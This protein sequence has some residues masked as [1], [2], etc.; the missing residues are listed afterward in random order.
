[1][2]SSTSAVLS[3]WE[4]FLDRF[5]VAY[6]DTSTVSTHTSMGTVYKKK[7]TF[8]V[9]PEHMEEFMCEYVRV[10]FEHGHAQ[11]LTERPVEHSSGGILKFDL[12]FKYDADHLERLFTEQVAKQ[13][14]E[15]VNVYIREHIVI[16][17]DALL[18]AYVFQRPGPYRKDLIVKDGIHIMYPNLWVNYA[19]HHYLRQKLI[20]AVTE[21]KT[22][23]CIPHTNT[24]DDVIDESIIERNGWLMYGSTKENL[25]PYVLTVAYDHDMHVMSDMRSPGEL[26]RF[27]SIRKKLSEP[28]YKKWEEWHNFQDNKRKKKRRDAE[29]GVQSPT[30]QDISELEFDDSVVHDRAHIEKLV[31][32]LSH[33]R[34]MNYTT[35]IEVGFC[36]HNLSA[37]LFDLWIQFSKQNFDK[38]YERLKHDRE[39]EYDEARDRELMED[40]ADWDE[41]L[42][43]KKSCKQVQ[44]D[45]FRRYIKDE[46]AWYVD[47]FEKWRRFTR[48][49]SCLGIGSLIYWAKKDNEALFRGIR[50][51]KIRGLIE[52]SVRN[53]SHKKIADVLYAKHKHQFVCSD[54]KTNVWYGWARHCWEYM[55]GTSIIQ[56]KIKDDT[57]SLIN[58]YIKIKDMVYKDVILNN[59]ELQDM[60][61]RYETMERELQSMNMANDSIERAKTI[62]DEIKKCKTDRERKR[63]ELFKEHVR[64]YEDVITRF[65]E[66][67]GQMENIVKNAKSCFYDKDFNNKLNANFSLFLFNNGVFDLE[68]MT[69][70][71]GRPDDYLSIE[72]DK[73]Q[74]DYIEYS[75]DM[76][77]PVFR[78]I[79]AYFRQ[80]IAHDEKREFFLTLLASCL[81]GGNNN[82]I[83]PIL[84]GSGSNAKTLT[85]SFIEDCFVKYG[86][87]LNSAFLTQKRNKSSSASP[88][89]HTV[90]DCR[91]VTSEEPDQDDELNTAIIKEITGNSKVSS[92]TLF[93]SKMTT[94]VPQFT[95]FLI[96]NDLPHIKSFDGGTWRR[97]V[98]ISFD[99]KFV[100]NPESQEWAGL[101]NVYKIN[102]TLRMEM[103]SW[104]EPFMYLL[105]H[106]YYRRFLSMGKNLKIPECVQAFTNKFKTENDHVAR[107]IDEHV[108]RV[109]GTERLRMSD[110]YKHLQEWWL[111]NIG[112]S[113]RVP[114]QTVAKKSFEKKFGAHERNGWRGLRYVHADANES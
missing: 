2:A 102:R 27:F 92:R 71:E 56:R 15:I 61:A 13:C 97:I 8:R 30:I 24:I 112:E 11:Y 1:M 20:D 99:S 82:N 52:D 75:P 32:I 51:K 28:H 87:K 49:E 86:G 42:Q 22:F 25:Q 60:D 62:K 53:P 108:Q 69:F 100:D 103:E 67:T 96:C 43:S 89:Y 70:R 80:V 45:I 106:K 110:V 59:A 33:E 65:L 50:F 26:C 46:K 58:D 74:I 105:I 36:L 111:L 47:C 19:L 41:I 109:G 44:D 12:D 9:P 90:I 73:R 16:D 23:V 64:P 57:D 7:G 84:T 93:Q 38:T 55:D 10:V 113:E 21:K 88:E 77:D 79:E 63:K 68:S 29:L 83:F 31:G 34:A 54:F 5:R 81:E 91:I 66:N 4:G 104:K 48:K 35:W 101:E 3:K 39:R 94:K 78:D 6:R 72:D 14:V 114:S 17:D 98:V 107:F 18:H 85:I 76:S 95:P 40:L 37:S